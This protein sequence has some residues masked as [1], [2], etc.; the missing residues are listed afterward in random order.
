MTVSRAWIFRAGAQ[1]DFLSECSEDAGGL[2]AV[3]G[4]RGW[5][6]KEGPGQTISQ[7]HSFSEIAILYSS[8]A[9][10]SLA[11]QHGRT[12]MSSHGMVSGSC[13]NNGS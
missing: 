2:P 6:P 7:A 5:R 3:A 10:L 13:C 9:E 12:Q 1:E 8:T 11:V 4:R